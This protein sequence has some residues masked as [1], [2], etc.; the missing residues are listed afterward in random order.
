MFKQQPW[1]AY[2]FLNLDMQVK[3]I[4]GLIAFCTQLIELCQKSCLT[5]LFQE[6]KFI[7]SVNR[8]HI[9]F[10][11]VIIF[12]MLLLALRWVPYLFAI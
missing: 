4:V 2:F 11:K 3:D 8:K 9:Y 12:Y 5:G 1:I 10:A 6:L 7:V